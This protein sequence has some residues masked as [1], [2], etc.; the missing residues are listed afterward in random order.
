MA[1]SNT[2]AK[3]QADPNRESATDDIL[4]TLLFKILVCALLAYVSCR[5]LNVVVK[6]LG[7]VISP[8][9]V[10][11]FSSSYNSR[12]GGVKR[13]LFANL[14]DL[15]E[16]N[17][18]ELTILEVGAG[19]GANFQYYPKCSK[20]IAV[21]T[22]ERY[23]KYLQRKA[24]D[25]G[26]IVLDRFVVA[27]GEDMGDILNDSVDA[28]VSTLVMSGMQHP[29]DYVREVKRILKPGGMFFYMEH[30]SAS[31]NSWTHLMQRML[32]PLFVFCD[33]CHLT[34]QTWTYIDMGGFR[35][36]EYSRFFAPLKGYM[37]VIRPHLVG[38]AMK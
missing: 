7:S 27:K 36:L 10:N 22:N 37:Q 12:M 32:N 4:E 24:M 16:R 17:G 14:A 38:S 31:K 1:D 26:H 11:C 25:T 35:R 18:G 15:Q 28:V 30:V 34:R 3:Q 19:G 20:I 6:R 33:G 9:F 29:E 13:R 5:V 2:E 21:D 8:L 23:Q